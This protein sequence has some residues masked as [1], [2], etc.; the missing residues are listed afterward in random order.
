MLCRVCNP[1]PRN[2][3]VN[4]HDWKLEL[5]RV[6]PRLKF[7][8]TASASKEWR[9]HLEQSVKHEKA[10]IESFPE[11]KAQLIKIGQALRKAGVYGVVM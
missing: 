4:A 8:S 5:E 1:P 7:K 11:T 2:R 3:Q 9:T 10:M 6:G